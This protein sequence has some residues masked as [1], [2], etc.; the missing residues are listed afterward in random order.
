MSGVEIQPIT[1]ASRLATHRDFYA[2][3]TTAEQRE[4]QGITVPTVRQRITLHLS[5]EYQRQILAHLA[6]HLARHTRGDV[7]ASFTVEGDMD[8]GF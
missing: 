2:D 8:A 6:A 5:P 3:D 7:I 4:A 1:T